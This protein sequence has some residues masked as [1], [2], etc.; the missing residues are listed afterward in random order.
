M[1]LSN[2]IFVPGRG[3]FKQTPQGGA[4][5]SQPVSN[6]TISSPEEQAKNA[7]LGS[8]LRSQLYNSSNN[9]ESQYGSLFG[10]RDAYQGPQSH[11][12]GALAS[13][14]NERLQGK[15]DTGSLYEYQTRFTDRDGQSQMYA[16]NNIIEDMYRNG[17]SKNQISQHLSGTANIADMTPDWSDYDDRMSGYYRGDRGSTGP[18][19]ISVEDREQWFDYDSRGG[20]GAMVN[21]R[22]DYNIDYDSRGNPTPPVNPNSSGPGAAVNPRIRPQGYSLFSLDNQNMSDFINKRIES[23]SGKGMFGR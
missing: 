5:Y 3:Y 21:P 15:Y 7:E 23:L 9:Y 2:L 22:R 20:P 4:D 17:Y 19:G 12:I 1:N 14:M 6:P 16:R 18:G 8:F 10:A 11:W 13:R